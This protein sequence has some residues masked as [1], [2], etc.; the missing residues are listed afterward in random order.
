MNPAIIIGIVVVALVI[1][2]GAYVLTSNGGKSAQNGTTTAVTSAPQTTEAMVHYAVNLGDNATL[3]KYLTNASGFTLYLYTSDTPNS[4]K[5][6]CY[7]TCATY[8]PAFYATDLTVASGLNASLFGT[9]NRT[10]GSKQLTYRGWPLYTY[11]KDKAPGEVSGEGASGTWFVL[12]FP[13]LSIPNQTISTTSAAST[14]ST[15]TPPANS[16][17][18]TAMSNHSTTISSSPTTS[19]GGSSWG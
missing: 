14:I 3:G 11:V 12:T 19:V 10:D 1:I 8:W 4:G 6:A 16:S 13:T 9:I 17:Q 2:G 15:T 18:T 7:G 5:S